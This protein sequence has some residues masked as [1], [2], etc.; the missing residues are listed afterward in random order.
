MYYRDKNGNYV[1]YESGEVKTK[2]ETKA[3]MP[4][5]YKK[6]EPLSQNSPEVVTVWCTFTKAGIHK[7][8]AAATD[9]RLAPVSYLAHPHRHIFHF[10]C[11]IQVYH[12]DRDIEFIMMKE[13]LAGLFGKPEDIDYNSCEMLARKC[14]DY[15]NNKW[16]NRKVKVT[17]SEDNE[18]G[19]TIY[20]Y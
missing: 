14:A 4:Q 10:H 9:P 6:P 19:A 20:R 15:M 16:P 1:S 12:D 17:V 18:N 7:Y 2:P 13:E 11:E 5:Y 8:P 3:K